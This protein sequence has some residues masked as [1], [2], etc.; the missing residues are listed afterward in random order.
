M[1]A[2][3]VLSADDLAI[4]A[5]YQAEEAARNQA[6]QDC[7]AKKA[8]EIASIDQKTAQIKGKEAAI[9]QQE[10]ELSDQA[11]ELKGAKDPDAK[12]KRAE[13]E[14]QKRELKKE[15]D[16][17]KKEENANKKE[18]ANI[19]KRSCGKPLP[20]GR[21]CVEPDESSKVPAD[22]SFGDDMNKLYG[23]KVKFEDLVD[24]EGSY[25]KAY[26][27]WWP[28]EKGATT[29]KIVTDK[30]SGGN[31]VIQGGS[32]SGTSIG[33]GNDLGPQGKEAYLKEL[34]KANKSV[35]L[36]PEK[37]KAMKEKIDPYFGKMRSEA[38]AYLR[39][40]PLE[41][42]TDELKLLNAR[43]ANV[44]LNKATD[45]KGFNKLSAEDQ[46]KIFKRIINTGE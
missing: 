1:T 34:D 31:A 45:I 12:E 6:I 44:A 21:N 4:S 23:T 38:C 43:S 18:I 26:I 41:L 32:H 46:T 17:L 27:P 11:K 40:H 15:N 20:K 28:I 24:Q 22:Y 39:A 36:S 10:K 13:L 5:R 42:D 3:T 37:L 25:A 19:V 30:Y 29:F 8:S 2:P 9:K 35:K 33:V 14:K 16:A 7:S